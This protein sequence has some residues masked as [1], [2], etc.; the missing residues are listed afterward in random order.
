[1]GGIAGI[2]DFKND[3]FCQE[4]LLETMKESIKCRGKDENGQYVNHEIALL[5][6][7]HAVTDKKYGHQPMGALI[8]DDRYIIV[9]DGELYNAPQLRET[10]IK[11]GY[12]FG[13]KSDT[14]VVLTAY[15]CWAESCVKQLDGMFAFAVW[16]NTKKRLFLARDRLGQKPLFYHQTENG[17]QFSSLPRTLFCSNNLPPKVTKE[18]LCY[19]LSNN[20]VP[21]SF[22][23]GI[24]EVPPGYFLFI[25][26]DGIQKE[27]YYTL[28]EKEL[29]TDFTAACKNLCHLLKSAVEKQIP[30]DNKAG[31]VL[32]PQA[33]SILL[34]SL[35][36][37]NTAIH[38]YTSRQNT[39]G[40]KKVTKYLNAAHTILSQ[41]EEAEK[42]ISEIIST[43]GIPDI[44]LSDIILYQLF[45]AA[46]PKTD[47]LLAGILTKELFSIDKTSIIDMQSVSPVPENRLKNFLKPDYQSVPYQY[48][49]HETTT[50][51]RAQELMKIELDK[52]IRH[53]VE[54]AEMLAGRLGIE[55]RL[56][57]LDSSV[58]EALFNIPWQ[59]RK[60]DAGNLYQCVT[61]SLIPP[62]IQQKKFRFVFDKKLYQQLKQLFDQ[63]SQN[64]NSDC[65]AIFQTE[66]IT[67]ALK[68][69]RD[70]YFLAQLM[71][72]VIQ[73]EYW[74]HKYSV[75]IV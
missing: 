20:I 34:A 42:S 3:L 10:L 61:N 27:Q 8:G 30:I 63:I 11:K 59:Y 2:V 67:A 4:N 58:I 24:E 18:N 69:N 54:K 36:A 70:Q 39:V 40:A 74:I 52:N 12:F 32:F 7:R 23:Q 37:K 56:P 35:A 16:D 28:P 33:D 55:L 38:T 5:N 72:Q 15:A 41:T 13:G 46:A 47:I 60:T 43:R 68:E 57:F 31:I 26:Q 1:M 50:K 17:V 6:A 19:L 64:P 25:N 66:E 53:C 73:T 22:F 21:P 49:F 51:G 62:R 45:K 75:E 29:E 71:L 44:C 9:Y 14:E 65:H 48:T